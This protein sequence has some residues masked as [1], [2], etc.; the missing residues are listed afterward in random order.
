MENEKNYYMINMQKILFVARDLHKRGYEK[1]RVVPSVSPSGLSWR[2]QYIVS[3]GEKKSIVVSNWIS[4]FIINENEE[5]KQ[6]P[7]ELA[8]LFEKENAKFLT[9]CKGKN[10]EYVKWYSDML[11]TLQE[12]ELPYAFDDYF[13]STDFWKTSMENEI[14]ILPGESCYYN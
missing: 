14:K 6:S 12:G 3:N 4:N 2:C 7:Q 13:S 1:L 11:D 9:K 5:I 10:N 8:D